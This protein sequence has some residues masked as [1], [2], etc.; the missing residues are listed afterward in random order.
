MDTASEFWT[1][2][3][4]ELMTPFSKAFHKVDDVLVPMS[5]EEYNSWIESGVGQEKPVDGEGAI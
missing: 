5:V 4:L 3:E 1:R 2:E